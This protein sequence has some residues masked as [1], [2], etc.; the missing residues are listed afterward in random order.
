MIA[1]AVLSYLLLWWKGHS[2]KKVKRL[3]AQAMLE[4]AR[5]ETEVII[6]DARLAANQETLK[7]REEMEQSFAGRRAERTEL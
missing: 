2:F 7:L 3:E 1:G 5:S 6:R 4:K